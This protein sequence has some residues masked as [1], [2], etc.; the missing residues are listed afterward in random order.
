[1]I[2]RMDVTRLI[3]YNFLNLYDMKIIKVNFKKISTLTYAKKY[4]RTFVNMDSA[5]VWNAF[6]HN[7][8]SLLFRRWYIISK[9]GP[10]INSYI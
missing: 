4:K 6:C 7:M 10:Y 1:M 8:L 2:L 5:I 3:F 9:N